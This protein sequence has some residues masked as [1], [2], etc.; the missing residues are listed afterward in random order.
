MF[1]I[2]RNATSPRCGAEHEERRKPGETSL[3]PSLR[4][5]D[6]R[7]FRRQSRIFSVT[8]IPKYPPRRVARFPRSVYSRTHDELCSRYSAL[9]FWMLNS[10]NVTRDQRNR[11]NRSNRPPLRNLL[12]HLKR[13]RRNLASSSTK[14]VRRNLVENELGSPLEITSVSS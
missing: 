11:S 3:G 13:D 4:K 14:T 5:R 7:C 6:N 8:L 1:S 9:G 2:G 10:G 12:T